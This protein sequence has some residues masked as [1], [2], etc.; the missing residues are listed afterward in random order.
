[1][2]HKHLRN[3]LLRRHLR[4]SQAGWTAVASLALAASPA[5]LAQTQPATPPSSA[6]AAQK[7]AP[8]SAG[9]V[10][11]W[12]R[13]Q[14][15]SWSSWD[16]GGQ[17]RL[18]YEMFDGAGPMAPNNDFQKHGVEN[19]NAYLWSREKLHLGYNSKWFGAY[20]EGR[21][22]NAASDDDVRN[23]GED[24]FDLHQA[25]LTLGNKKEFPLFAKIGRQEFIYGDERLI[26]ASDW[27]NTARVFDAAKLRFENEDFWVD[28][29]AGRVV[30]P[31]D[32]EF[33]E[34]DTHDWFFGA[35]ASSKTLVP[36]Q[37]SQLY[38]LSRNV[39]P[40]G[41]AN[42]SARDI[43]TVGLRVKSLPAKLNGW[44]YTVEV[45][46]Q[47]GSISQGG[48]RRDQDA[49]AAAVGGG[50]T[51]KDVFAAP[52]VGLGY[53][54]STGD[55]DPDDGESE[56]LDNLFPTNHKFYGIMDVI[57]WRNI[58]NPRLSLSAKP[59]KRVTVALDYHLFWLADT[60]DSFYPQGGSG[61][62]ANGYGKNPG[63]D[64]FVG[65]ELDLDVNYTITPWASIR[66]GYAHFFPG[67]YVKSSKQEVGGEVGADW[68][69][70]QTTF[71]F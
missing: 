14:S 60:Q 29:F 52:R 62:N 37:E 21:N 10:N 3:S 12:L 31:V 48:E 25:Y 27:G 56:T 71:S 30:L 69:F 55:S 42:T 43:Y 39:S 1:M 16:V 6:K 63:Y 68:F 22:S 47:F 67:N 54:F 64:S 18:R 23:P 44:D 59:H 8:A 36:I 4:K 46:K 53:D 40:G 11:D 17:V 61:R 20:V 38:F 28:A 34:N 33:N 15:P 66:G 70:I 19:D 57:G 58:H 2:Y 13:E 32:G 65:S 7:T 41:P 49:W 45:V 50:Y 51:W 26:G 5:V 9:L 24:S 35:Y